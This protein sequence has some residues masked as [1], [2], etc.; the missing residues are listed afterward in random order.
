MK[1]AKTRKSIW[2]TIALFLTVCS[3][4]ASCVGCSRFSFLSKKNEEPEMP[5]D[6]DEENNLPAITPADPPPPIVY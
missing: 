5:T 1:S 2:T 6:T 3:L 4:L